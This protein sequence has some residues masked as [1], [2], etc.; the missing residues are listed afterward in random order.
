MN[1]LKINSLERTEGG[2][3]KGGGFDLGYILH[4]VKINKVQNSGNIYEINPTFISSLN[5]CV[6]IFKLG[7]VLILGDL[8]V[9]G[10]L[11][12]FVIVIYIYRELVNSA[13]N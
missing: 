12:F 1:W 10:N 3:G 6:S 9:L 11:S 5:L 8:T 7:N 4:G 13:S 2:Q